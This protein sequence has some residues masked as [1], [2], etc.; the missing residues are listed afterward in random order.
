MIAAW[1]LTLFALGGI[2][3]GVFPGRSRGFSPKLAAAGGGLLSGIAVFW[4]FPEIVAV[5]SWW[6]AALLVAFIF[7]LLFTFDRTLHRLHHSFSDSAAEAGLVAGPLLIAAGIH[8]F[9]DGWSVRFASMDSLTNLAVPAG[10]ALHKV[11]EGLALGLVARESFRSRNTAFLVA[12]SVECFTLIGAWIEP[13]ANRVGAAEFGHVWLALVLSVIAGSF[14]FLGAH[15][16][17]PARRKPELMIAFAG[18]FVLAFGA[19]VLQRRFAM[20]E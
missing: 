4:L 18:A 19:A 8:S 7:S 3:M 5:S 14:L 11:P 2:G 1:L 10:L 12:A 20:G 16:A 6:K 9:L 13:V 17:L 15:T